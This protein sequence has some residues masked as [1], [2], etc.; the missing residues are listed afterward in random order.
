MLSAIMASADNRKYARNPGWRSAAKETGRAGEEVGEEVEAFMELPGSS[1]AP[2]CP[3]QRH[4]ESGKTRNDGALVDV[5]AYDDRTTCG[6][7]R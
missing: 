1:K 2:P 4:G 3:M 5:N 6:A 7:R